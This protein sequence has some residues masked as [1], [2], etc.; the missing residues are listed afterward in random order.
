MMNL[1]KRSATGLFA[2]TS[3]LGH[4]I[5]GGIAALLVTWAIQPQARPV[6]SMVAAAGA[7]I[8]FRGCPL[9]WTIGLVETA[10][11]RFRWR[12]PRISPDRQ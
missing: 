10:A 5:R 8:A 7:V 11:Q 6:L 12:R 3:L 2:S 9:C 1:F 4:L